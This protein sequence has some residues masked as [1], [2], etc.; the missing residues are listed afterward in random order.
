MIPPISRILAHYLVDTDYAIMI[1]L[2]L[3]KYLLYGHALESMSNNQALLLELSPSMS[4][5]W[6]SFQ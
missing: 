6:L 4:I 3:N 5:L 1:T 2:T